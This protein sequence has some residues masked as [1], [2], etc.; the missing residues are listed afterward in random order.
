[1]GVSAPEVVL[2]G[3]VGVTVPHKWGSVPHKWFYGAG[4]GSLCLVSGGLCPVSGGLWGGI[5]GLH[6]ISG[7]LCPINGS[8]GWDGGFCAP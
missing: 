8:M 7:G 3:G 4:W 5:G 1:M 6:P 2:W